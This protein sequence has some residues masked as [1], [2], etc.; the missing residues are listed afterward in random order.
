MNLTKKLKN[1]KME[2]NSNYEISELITN[3]KKSKIF[4]SSTKEIGRYN[5]YV[6]SNTYKYI[7]DYQ[8]D[9]PS[10][11]IS[12]GGEFYVHYAENKY[13]FSTDIW[14]IKIKDKKIVDKYIYYFLESKKELINYKGFQGSG[15]KHLDKNFIKKIK[16][17][18]PQIEEQRKI[19]KLLSM[20]DR[21]IKNLEHKI[22]K[23]E[24]IHKGLLDK[25]F[26]DESLK[27]KKKKLKDICF[28]KRGK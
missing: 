16:I 23:I 25:F 21:F 19:I 15:L 9:M 24:N 2:N 7:D 4:A 6:C 10:I 13:S 5:F 12:T 11:L 22:N 26:K 17:I 27:S 18:I 28:V 14:G 20:F 3:L 1:L 8:Y